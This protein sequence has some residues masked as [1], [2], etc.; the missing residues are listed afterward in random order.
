MN[1]NIDNDI[2]RKFKEDKYIPKSTQKI[3]SEA[4]K[5]NKSVIYK[6]ENKKVKSINKIIAI[7]TCTVGILIGSITIYAVQGGKIAD[8]PVL[9]WLGVSG[10]KFSNEYEKY[11]VD[12]NEKR[13]VHNDTTI[14]L[15]SSVCDE[16][17]TILEF[18]VKLDEED[19]NY[20]QNGEKTF[21]KIKLLFNSEISYDEGLNK[22]QPTFINN[23]NIIIDGK[24]YWIRPRA[25]QIVRKISDYEYKVFQLYFLTDKELGKKEDFEITLN[26]IIIGALNDK[27]KE[28][29]RYIEIKEKVSVN[30]SKSKSL[31][32][33]SVFYPNCNTST[34]KNMTKQVEQV[35]VTPLQIILKVTS[36]IDNVSSESLGDT[37]NEDFIG[38]PDYLAYDSNGNEL[39]T[40][41]YETKRTVT[42]QDGRVEE[43]E[44]SDVKTEEPFNNAT[45][46]LTEYIIIEK[47]ENTKSIK[48]VP[49]VIQP[50]GSPIYSTDD[51]KVKLQ[52]FDINF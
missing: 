32:N 40:W 4:L 14:D 31:E 26:G 34:Y 28:N 19:K 22:Y 18:D 27:L 20:L 13:I 38:S 17:F 25:E 44:P 41:Y 16:G 1:K 51:E 47:K 24:N 39:S 43:W 52:S 12:V 7:T 35:T 21:E 11:K 23:Y 3:I 50:S 37:R 33:T 5:D 36:T 10:I 49:I 6:F 9:E 8:K 15:I 42:Y 30:V 45:I 46:E 48:V 2:R 29:D